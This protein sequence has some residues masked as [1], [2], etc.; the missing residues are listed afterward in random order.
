MSQFI[1]KIEKNELETGLELNIYSV[2]EKLNTN[3]EKTTTNYIIFTKKD[4]FKRLNIKTDKI[5]LADEEF[6]NK[7]EEKLVKIEISNK[8]LYKYLLNELKENNIETYETDLIEEHKHI[9]ENNIKLYK[10][11]NLAIPK[12]KY[13]STD[14]ET[15]GGMSLEEQEIV[16]I[17]T[18]SPF[19]KKL[20]KVFVNCEKLKEKQIK[21]LEKNKKK[22]YEIVIKKNEKELLEEFKDTIIKFNPQVIIGWNVIDFDFRIIRD[23]MIFHKIE[24]N[25]SKYEGNCKL[26]IV[27]D[28]YKDSTMDCSGTIVFDAI[29][30]LRTNFISFEDYKLNTVA[31]EVLADEKVDIMEEN[32]DKVNVIEEHFKN[33]PALLAD[34]NF[35]DSLLVSKIIEK[36]NLIDLMVE[37]SIITNTPLLKVKSPIA[38]LDIMYLSKLHEKKIV[39]PSNFNFDATNPISGAYVISPKRGFYK[40]VFVFDFKSLYPSIIMTFNIDPYSFREDEKGKI[41][42]PNGATFDKETGILPEL[43]LKLYKERDVAKRDKDKIK[44]FALK[45]TMNSFYGAVAS[46]KSR[47]YNKMVGGAI[48]AFGREIIKKAKKYGEER[49][50]KVVYGDTDSVFIH[51]SNLEGKSFE[52]KK[53]LGKELEKDLNEHFKKWVE[54]EFGQTSFLTIEMEKIFSKFFIASKKRYVGYDEISKRTT[55]TGMEAIRG[56]WTDVAKLFQREL[57]DKIFA[58]E[59]KEKIEK[60]IQ[61]FVGD[62]NKGK[63]DEMIIYKKK[64]TKPLHDYVKTTPPH[65]KAAREVENFAGRLVKYV[66]LKG[67]PKHVSL[68]TNNDEYDYEHYVEKQLKGVSDDILESFGIDFDEVI[69]KKSQKSL[70]RFF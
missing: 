16:M 61:N 34:Y 59:K 11:N 28:F 17:S 7:N 57:I 14:I 70:D 35:K 41:K 32:N 60:F 9:I 69:R 12:L 23:R 31:K 62:L 3:V 15:I 58:E 55:F 44:S 26:R 30:L 43:I 65:V 24:F 56:D 63:F 49:G 52:E 38:S 40:D 20:S 45:T 39:G 66:M 37:R 46:P 22:E 67:G 68:L 13:V 36:L 18:Y 5:I 25:F 33:N 1:Y 54:K 21:E 53:K 4:K 6:L 47:F 19:D 48:T 51:V 10:N 8:E 64:I 27:K 42:A 29:Q 50:L 2:D